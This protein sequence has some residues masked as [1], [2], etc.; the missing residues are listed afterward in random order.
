M[1]TVN[2]SSEENDSYIVNSSVRYTFTPSKKLVEVPVDSPFPDFPDDD[3]DDD[4]GGW[5]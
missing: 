3:N 4:D 1:K 5:E 2:F